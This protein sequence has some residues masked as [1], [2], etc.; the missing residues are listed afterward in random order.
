MT[1]VIWLRSNLTMTWDPELQ[2][3]RDDQGR[4]WSETPFVLNGLQREPVE[5]MFN[6][7]RYFGAKQ[8]EPIS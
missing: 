7:K 2:V 6:Q 1:K 8:C 4:L 5:G 3:Y